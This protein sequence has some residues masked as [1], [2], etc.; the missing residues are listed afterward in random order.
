[1]SEPAVPLV[2]LPLGRCKAS[3]NCR[4]AE[5]NCSMICANCKGHSLL[6]KLMYRLLQETMMMNDDDINEQML[7]LSEEEDDPDEAEELESDFKT[8]I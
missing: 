8:L 1:M 3:R 5:M 7:Q 6:L 2:H 4:K